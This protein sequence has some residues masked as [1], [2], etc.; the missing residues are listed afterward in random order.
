MLEGD[1]P[2]KSGFVSEYKGGF[3]R[4][5]EWGALE[6]SDIRKNEIYTERGWGRDPDFVAELE[7]ELDRKPGLATKVC[8]FFDYS[9]DADGSM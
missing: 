2:V 8:C 3:L 7:R 9:F 6:E 4:V 1:N 5:A